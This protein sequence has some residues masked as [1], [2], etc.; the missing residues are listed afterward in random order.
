[1]DIAASKRAEFFIYGLI[2]LVVL[3]F[4]Y[5]TLKR[6]GLIR[7]KTKDEKQ[8]SKV[9]KEVKSEKKVITTTVNRSDWFNPALWSQGSKSKLLPE[10]T[11]RDYA[12]IIRKAIKGLGT[13]ETAIN[14]IFRKLT[15]KI[16]VSQIAFFYQST[17]NRDLATDLTND[18]SKKELQIMYEIIE[19]I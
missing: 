5:V 3:I 9:K 15:D 6:L 4:L 19:N 17:N 14:G 10:Q 7:F 18:L 2:A 12:S 1:M 8:A 11:A 16:Q 13:D